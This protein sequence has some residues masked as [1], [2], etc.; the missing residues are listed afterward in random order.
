MQA[1]YVWQEPYLAAIIGT[2]SR[3][4][5]LR[6]YHASGM[7]AVGSESP[8][9]FTVKATRR[10]I[11]GVSMIPFRSAIIRTCCLTVR[12]DIPSASPISL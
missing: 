5:G 12:H 9:A 11:S 8:I 1:D 3:S 2:A 7:L 10:L 4:L 6:R